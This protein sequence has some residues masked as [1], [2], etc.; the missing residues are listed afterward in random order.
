M[1]RE[2]LSEIGAVFSDVTDD[3]AERM[4]AEMLQA[5]RIACYGVGR[6]GLMMKALGMRLMHLGLESAPRSRAKFLIP[7]NR[8]RSSCKISRSFIHCPFDLSDERVL[9]S[10]TGSVL[11]C[12]REYAGEVLDTVQIA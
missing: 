7:S 11:H 2:A 9:K 3:V 10:I 8:A 5:R 4:C 1:A 12:R 6:E